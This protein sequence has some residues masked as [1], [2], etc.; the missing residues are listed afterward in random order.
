MAP[1]ESPRTRK[2]GQDYRKTL[3]IASDPN[4]F[5][6]RGVLGKARCLCQAEE[7]H[8][9][10]GHGADVVVHTQHLRRPPTSWT[11]DSNIGLVLTPAV[12]PVS[13]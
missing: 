13:A 7:D 5:D 12:V 8:F 6:S 3:E 11:I 4:R 10:A 1:S 9:F 2:R